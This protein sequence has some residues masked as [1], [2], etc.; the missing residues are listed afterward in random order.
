MPQL[1][2]RI[3]VVGGANVDIGGIPLNTLIA[4]D[5]NPGRVRI[6]SGGVGRNIAENAVLLGLD[7]ELITAVGNDANGRMLLENCSKKG[8]GT[9]SVLVE[10]D[11]GTSVYLF[12]NDNRNDLHCAISDMDIQQRIT[13][14]KLAACLEMLNTMNAV[15]IDAN[16]SQESIL[17]LAQN[18][19]VPIFC[20]PVSVTKAVKLKP[21]L[22][23]IYCLK[24]NRMEAE[25]LAGM[26]IRDFMDAAEA[27][28]RLVNAGAKK[29]VLTMGEQGA[30]CAD[31]QSCSFLPAVARS[32][33]N[34]TGAGDAFMAGLVWAYCEDLDLRK[35]GVAGVAAARIALS[36]LETVNP[37]MSRSVLVRSMADIEAHM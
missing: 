10:E 25:L 6:S 11:V 9:S 36:A 18:L 29:V 28:R 27:A 1:R 3:A 13:P 14:E 23:Y 19:R 31:A 37:K 15:V 21:A 16:L 34:T 24:P 22:P 32:V 7:V 8:I 17:Y 26:Q 5:S 33:V 20:D 35:S 4:R 30:L 2:K 12:I